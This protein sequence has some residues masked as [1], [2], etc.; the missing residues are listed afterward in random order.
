MKFNSMVESILEDFRAPT[1]T[2]RPVKVRPR[3]KYGTVNPQ[4]N[5]P[6]STKST[7]GFKGQFSGKVNTLLLQLPGSNPKRRSKNKRKTKSCD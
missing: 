5:E 4:L 2:K 7:S 6:H 3:G 1:D